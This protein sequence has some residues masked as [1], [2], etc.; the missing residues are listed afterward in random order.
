MLGFKKRLPAQHRPKLQRT[1]RMLAWAMTG[2][3]D[4]VVATNLQL[5]I[6]GAA[7]GWHRLSKAT[8]DGSVLTVI[9]S[10]VVQE[11]DGYTVIADQEPVRMVLPDP[12][13]LPHE[14]RQRVTA[15]VRHPSHHDLGD[16]GMWLAARRVPGMDGLSWIVRYDG[17]VDATSPEVIALT[18]ALVQETRSKVVAPDG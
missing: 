6:A 2:A 10:T 16:G 13:N 9:P 3:G 15:S 5:W 1:E 8:W 18:G 7:T 17:G 14:V 4:A 11:R 12:G